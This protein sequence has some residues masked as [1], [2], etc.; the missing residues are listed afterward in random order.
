MQFLK[1]AKKNFNA[2]PFSIY[3]NISSVVSDLCF[4]LLCCTWAFNE[5]DISAFHIE[6]Y[7]FDFDPFSYQSHETT[8]SSDRMYL[9]HPG[10][11]GSGLNTERCPSVTEP[12]KPE[13]SYCSKNI[14]VTSKFKRKKIWTMEKQRCL[15]FFL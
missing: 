10:K 6:V 14:S 8:R 9:P 1:M 3:T 15:N 7:V 11:V 2:W 12:L 4:S 5:F 13:I